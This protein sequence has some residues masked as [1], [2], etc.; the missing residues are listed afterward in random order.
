MPFLGTEERRSRM[1]MDRPVQGQGQGMTVFPLDFPL[2]FPRGGDRPIWGISLT[3]TPPCRVSTVEFRLRRD[4]KVKR[5]CSRGGSRCQ[6]AGRF[7]VL[8]ASR[9]DSR[10]EVGSR[11]GICAGPLLPSMAFLRRGPCCC[12]APRIRELGRRCYWAVDAG[13]GLRVAGCGCAPCIDA[14]HGRQGGGARAGPM[15]WAHRRAASVPKM[16]RW[17]GKEWD[18]SGCA[19]LAHN[20]AVHGARAGKRAG[21]T[22]AVSRAC[23]CFMNE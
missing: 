21:S 1:G 7:W 23:F 10:W 5:P 11:A 20:H 13:C 4:L 12:K 6:C 19:H 17:A 18:S 3:R 14:S 2:I 16:R 9:W 8:R 22:R 15:P